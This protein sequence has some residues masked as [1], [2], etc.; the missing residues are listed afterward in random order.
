MKLRNAELSE[1]PLEEEEILDERSEKNDGSENDS[2]A[3]SRSVRL[4]VI[5]SLISLC[6][7]PTTASRISAALLGTPPA[8]KFNILAN[9][10]APEVQ[11]HDDQLRSAA[12]AMPYCPG[13]RQACIGEHQAKCCPEAEPALASKRL[14]TGRLV[15]LLLASQGS[16]PA[17][18]RWLQ[19][20]RCSHLP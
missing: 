12:S 3:G 16:T 19:T 8:L 5:K 15:F 20:C 10:T 9:V 2:G 17:I 14:K 7:S 6:T 11:A 13:N 1:K 4:P 18:L